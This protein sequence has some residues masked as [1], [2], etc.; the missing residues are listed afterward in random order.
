MFKVRASAGGKLIVEP[1]GKSN[2]EKYNDACDSLLSLETRLS[3]FKNKYCKSAIEI[4]DKK[5]PE[6]KQLIADLEPIKDKKELSETTK[7]Y[8]YEWLT[9][10]I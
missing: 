4:R 7:T 2:L 5:I 3:E 1:T 9:E 6:T 8:L 10:K